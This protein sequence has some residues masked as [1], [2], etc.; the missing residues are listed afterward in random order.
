MHHPD[1]RVEGKIFATLGY[2]DEHFAMVKLTPQQ[3]RQV[4]AAYPEVF[5]PVKGKWGERG[6]THVRLKA[7]TKELATTALALAWG[8]S[9]P[10]KKDQQ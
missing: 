2:P 7:A 5:V 10:K 8:N 9:A 3:Q 4:I 6:C 1:F